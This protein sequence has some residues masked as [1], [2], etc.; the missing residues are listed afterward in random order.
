ML[1]TK[2]IKILGIIQ[3]YS[4]KVEDKKYNYILQ[5]IM[6]KFKYIDLYNTLLY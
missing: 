3:K 2:L 6:C 4:I 1:K 5:G